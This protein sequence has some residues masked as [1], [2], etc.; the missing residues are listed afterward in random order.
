MWFSVEC[1]ILLWFKQKN[2]RLKVRFVFCDSPRC[3]VKCRTYIQAFI[4]HN[5]FI[6]ASNQNPPG[7]TIENVIF[8]W[9]CNFYEIQAKNRRLKLRFVFCDFP[10]RDVKCR[11]YIQAFILHNIFICASNQNPPGM[12][13][14]N[15]ILCLMCNFYMIQAKK[16]E[17][18]VR[19]VF[20]DSPRYDVKCRRYI[21]AFILHNIFICA[22]NQN[23]PGLTIQNV[24]LCW[25]CNFY[26]IH[27]RNRRLKVRFVFGDFPRHDVNCRRYIQAFILHNIF[28]CPSSQNSPGLTIEN[29][30]FSWMCNFYLIQ[31]KNRRLKVR[32]VF[33]H[34]PRCDVK[35]RRYIQ[36]FILHNIF[37]CAS[38]QNPPGLTIEN[39]IFCWMCNFSLIPAENRRLKVRFVFCDS[40]RCNDKCR[41]YIKPFYPS[42]HFDLCFKSE[43]TWI[44]HIK[45]DILLNV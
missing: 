23:P 15:G 28:I 11:R 10:T 29:V 45:C 32:F 21:Q 20:C 38:N 39:V 33:S 36:A 25:M 31:A 13:I 43:S 5:I 44:D 2:R 22:S 40:P 7:L 17:L 41:R 37:I 30:I 8:C 6:C 3:D 4:L 19:F 42:L 35:C 18:K 16:R 12:T 14:A 34:S 1:V 26:F 27:A 9:M 24:I